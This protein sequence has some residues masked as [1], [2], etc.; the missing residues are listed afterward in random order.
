[1]AVATGL[2]EI[3][4]LAQH[5][6]DAGLIDSIC[7]WASESEVLVLL[8]VPIEGCKNLAG[9]RRP[10]ENALQHYISL[11]PASKAAN[12]G[13][14]LKKAI[15]KGVGHRDAVTVKE[16]YPHA[17]YK[18]LWAAR[19]SGRLLDVVKARRFSTILNSQFVPTHVPPN[20]KRGN[21]DDR[22]NGLRYLRSLLATDMGL[23]FTHPLESPRLCFSPLE[24]DT[25]ADLYDACLGAVVGWL[26]ASRNS[27]A[28]LAGDDQHGE[29]LMLCDQWLK[30][31]LQS[32]GIVLRR[33]EEAAR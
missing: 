15:L 25:L 30:T 2:G 9:P 14:E 16:I 26:C 4:F 29:M 8:D 12:R 11:Y 33:L 5:L 21:H 10:I 18:F 31:R 24:M 1:M 13:E 22:R 32:H 3:K 17:I 23:K 28:W 6:D 7:K 19:E 20:Y 27:Y